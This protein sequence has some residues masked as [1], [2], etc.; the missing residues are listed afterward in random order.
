MEKRYIYAEVGENSNK[1]WH[2]VVEGTTM[3]ASWGRV[4]AEKCQSK[5][6]SFGSSGSAE[7]FLEKKGREKERK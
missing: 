2:G 5:T 4:G 6:F 7:S 3:V 1:Y